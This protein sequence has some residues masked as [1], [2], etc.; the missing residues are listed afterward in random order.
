MSECVRASC[1][2]HHRSVYLDLS[3]QWVHTDGWPCECRCGCGKAAHALGL[4]GGCYHRWANAGR[5]EDFFVPGLG[6]ARLGR[7]EDYLEL[8][9]RGLTRTEAARRVGVTKRTVQRYEAGLR[10]VDA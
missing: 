7:I 10:S 9:E 3:G 4:S 6:A 1:L 2:R 8:R 5:P